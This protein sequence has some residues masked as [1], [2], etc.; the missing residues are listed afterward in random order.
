MRLVHI[1]AVCLVR[2]SDGLQNCTAVCALCVKEILCPLVA[3]AVD[4]DDAD[5]DDGVLS[6][7]Y[8]TVI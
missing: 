7:I 4:D 5:A 1:A 3:A 8:L 2:Y 6:L